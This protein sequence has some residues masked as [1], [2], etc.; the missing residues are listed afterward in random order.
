MESS[1]RD[2]VRQRFTDFFRRLLGDSQVRE[3]AVQQ[4]RDQVD[5]ETRAQWRAQ[6]QAQ[7]ERSLRQQHGGRDGRG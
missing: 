4:T 5:A 3:Q 1:S 2:S 6:H 7:V